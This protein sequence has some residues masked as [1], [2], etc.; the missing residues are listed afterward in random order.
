M[1]IRIFCGALTLPVCSAALLS[2][3]GPGELDTAGQ[4]ADLLRSAWENLESQGYEVLGGT[5]SSG[6]SE[7]SA[8][9]T[10]DKDAIALYASCQG[11]RGD[12]EVTVNGVQVSMDCDDQGSVEMIEAHL[13]V[14]DRLL[15]VTDAGLPAE[16]QYSIIAVSPSTAT[17]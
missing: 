16:T 14:T 15:K 12:G 3:S 4:H 8:E 2:C 11:E 1:R 7:G 10:V 17:H 5:S 9:F 6:Q 13:D